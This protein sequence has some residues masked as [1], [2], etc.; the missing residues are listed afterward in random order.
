MAPLIISNTLQSQGGE[1]NQ[2]KNEWGDRSGAYRRISYQYC[3][4]SQSQPNNKKQLHQE[5]SG[6]A[7][8]SWQSTSMYT[9]AAEMSTCFWTPKMHLVGY[10][11]Y[12]GVWLDARNEAS[13][14]EQLILSLLHWPR[15]FL[16]RYLWS[17][18]T[19]PNFKTF[20]LSS[21]FEWLQSSFY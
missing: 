18:I 13:S 19:N 2:Q 3:F 11:I 5:V 20:L 15:V 8:S 14:P 7:S 6:K 12:A 1:N 17:S 21:I 16:Q 10:G 9:I 4:P